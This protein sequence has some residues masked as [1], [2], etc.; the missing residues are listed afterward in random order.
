MENDQSDIYTMSRGLDDLKFTSG[1]AQMIFATILL[2]IN[3]YFLHESLIEYGCYG[4]FAFGFFLVGVRH[5]TMI[6]PSKKFIKLTRG[7]LFIVSVKEYSRHDFTKILV[8]QSTSTGTDHNGIGP[9]R[10]N[11]TIFTY[12]VQLAL[13]NGGTKNIHSGSSRTEM[14]YFA[15]R[16]ANIFEVPFV[17][18]L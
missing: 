14:E 17:S 18:G 10:E 5:Q 1:I 9:T 2:V 16:I 15:Q 11:V 12:H 7:F 4:T 6:S 3:N 8:R 13:K